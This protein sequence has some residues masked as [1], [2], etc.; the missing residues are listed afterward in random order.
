MEKIFSLIP[1]HEQNKLYVDVDGQR[2]ALETCIV[3][4]SWDKANPGWAWKINKEDPKSD[5]RIRNAKF[6]IS[7]E[8]YRDNELEYAGRD[9]AVGK[10]GTGLI[11]GSGKPYVRAV[12]ISVA[13]FMR[14]NEIS[15]LMKE[16]PKVD[17]IRS[18]GTTIQ[19]K[20][21]DLDGNE[22][23]PV[24]GSFMLDPETP[25]I[26]RHKRVQLSNHSEWKG[27]YIPN[28][29]K[30]KT[31]PAVEKKPTPPAPKQEM[32]EPAIEHKEE[33]V[34]AP[35]SSE[36]T[37]TTIGAQCGEVLDSALPKEAEEPAKEIAVEVPAQEPVAETPAE[38]MPEQKEEPTPVAEAGLALDVP[39][40]QPA[41]TAQA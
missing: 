39:T 5:P 28:G 25:W 14:A 34:M 3:I 22:V 11:L 35:G 10:N 23:K 41:V 31:E 40:A 27:L 2:T 15:V 16:P 33:A 7:T 4:P 9:V 32:K 19:F 24:A 29:F 38:P 8:L 13:E 18:K 36:E 21:F 26:V 12:D 30:F 1:D 37:F 17:R 6:L 20:V